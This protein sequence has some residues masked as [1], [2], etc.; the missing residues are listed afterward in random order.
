MRN[1]ITVAQ[2]E[3]S[4]A[5]RGVTTRCA[6]AAAIMMQVPAAR[7]I[8]V[9]ENK[10][11][12]LDV[13]RHE[14]LV[15]RTPAAAQEFIRQWDAGSEVE[16]FSFTLTDTALIE[17][18]EPKVRAARDRVQKSTNKPVKRP[19]SGMKRVSGEPCKVS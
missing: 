8:R 4:I 13:A 2:P 10:I 6:I 9:D 5:Q 3:I 18:R 17:R 12:W 16:P 1:K 14:R 15:F 11:A 19:G 7:H